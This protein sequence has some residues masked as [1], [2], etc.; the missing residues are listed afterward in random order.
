MPRLKLTLPPPSTPWTKVPN[1][2]FDKV[3]PNL[4]DTELRI[5]LIL[6]RKTSGWQRPGHPTV[7][8]YRTLMARSGRGSD[9]VGKALKSLKARGL[10]H[11]VRAFPKVD[12]SK[13]LIKDYG[14][15][16][17]TQQRKD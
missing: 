7:L 16:R 13:P 5:L 6:I 9:A 15:R 1:V 12:T 17:A 2:L 14:K 4:K 11:T 10:I 8:S 3:I